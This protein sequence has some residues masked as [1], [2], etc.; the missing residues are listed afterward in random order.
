MLRIMLDQAPDEYLQ[1]L[2]LVYKFY[3]HSLASVSRNCKRWCFAFK[4]LIKVL[5]DA[6]NEVKKTNA[7]AVVVEEWLP[8]IMLIQ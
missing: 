7:P 3:C 6:G 2:W 4:M 1:G 5:K 8:Q